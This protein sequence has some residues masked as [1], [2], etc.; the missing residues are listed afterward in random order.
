MDV[1]GNTRLLVLKD[2]TTNMWLHRITLAV[3]ADK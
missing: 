3:D 2:E 1:T